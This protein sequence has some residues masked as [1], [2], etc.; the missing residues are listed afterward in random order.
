MRLAEINIGDTLRKLVRADL[1][2]LGIATTLVGKDIGYELRSCDPSPY[3]I[4]YTLT[5][6]RQQRSF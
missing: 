3:D 1:K 6:V 2:R 4:D 5:S